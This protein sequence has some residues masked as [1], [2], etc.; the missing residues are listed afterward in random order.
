[1][2][3]TDGW[4]HCTVTVKQFYIEYTEHTGLPDFHRAAVV[5]NE[6]RYDGYALE[7]MGATPCFRYCFVNIALINK[8]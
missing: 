1:M 5:A 2:V 4:Q 8:Q 3:F 6:N 7:S